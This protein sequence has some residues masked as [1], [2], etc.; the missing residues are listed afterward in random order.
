[1]EFTLKVGETKV[2]ADGHG[3]GGGYTCPRSLFDALEALDVAALRR[4]YEDVVEG[5]GSES[6]EALARFD[7]MPRSLKSVVIGDIG[8][9][10]GAWL[11]E[12]GVTV[13]ESFD[14]K[15]E[16]DRTGDPTARAVRSWT[17][18]FDHPWRGARVIDV[19]LARTQDDAVRDAIDHVV[20]SPLRDGAWDMDVVGLCTITATRR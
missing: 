6:D 13:V 15:W 20:N 1:M 19:D 9:C 3:I 8:G 11:C 14:D 7:D 10:A 17:V 2:H 16:V 5:Y 18:R 12:D 4:R